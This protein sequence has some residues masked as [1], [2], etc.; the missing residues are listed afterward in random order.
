M[1]VIDFVFLFHLYTFWYFLFHLYT[2][3]YFQFHLYKFWYFQFH[4]YNFDIFNF[5]YTSFDIFN[6]IYTSFDIFNF[7]Y[8]S[9]D[10]FNFIYTSLDIFKFINY[11]DLILLCL[12]PLS[13]IFQ[14]YHN[15]SL[16]GGRSWSTRRE[17]P[18]MSMQLVSFITCGYESSAPFFVI[19]K[20]GCEPMPYWW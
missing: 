5:I 12:T 14:L 9:L 2:C 4:L 16:S 6:F 3:W 8:T 15:D 11:I 19:Y 17:P 7:I 10:I 18:T 1:A 20:A 13:A